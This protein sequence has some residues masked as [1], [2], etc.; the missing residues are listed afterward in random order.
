MPNCLGFNPGFASHYLCDLGKFTC[1]FCGLVSF[2]V[3]GGWW[4]CLTRL[5]SS[6]STKYIEGCPAQRKRSVNAC[7]S[8]SL[9]PT[10]DTRR[11]LTLIRSFQFYVMFVNFKNVVMTCIPM[12]FQAFWHPKICK[13]MESLL[14]LSYKTFFV[15]LIQGRFLKEASTPWKY[16]FV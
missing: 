6:T 4:I 10:L 3:P 5:L 13:D 15:T 7:C 16:V 8:Q 1:S 12:V 11:M 14:T 9:L 2:S